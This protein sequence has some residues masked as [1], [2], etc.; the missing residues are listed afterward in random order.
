MEGRPVI[1][2]LSFV[3]KAAGF[4]LIP[5]AIAVLALGARNEARR[6]AEGSCPCMRADC[7]GRSVLVLPRR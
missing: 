1:K 3:G 6:R 5:V 2:L 7:P 4:L